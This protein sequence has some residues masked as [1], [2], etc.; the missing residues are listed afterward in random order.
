LRRSK[1]SSR[2]CGFESAKPIEKRFPLQL[3]GDPWLTGWVVE[4][5][6]CI[7][8]FLGIGHN[9]WNARIVIWHFYVDRVHRRR[10]F[11][12]L[13]LENIFAEAKSLGAT[14][15]WIETTN[16]NYPGVLAYK[17]LGFELCGFDLTLYKGTPSQGEFG[18]FLAR[19]L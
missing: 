14:T 8:G 3:D 12:R 5:D 2:W 19:S 6:G 1:T 9:P 13:L 7:R 18:L 11:G 4:E 17:R 16:V 15:A 10:G